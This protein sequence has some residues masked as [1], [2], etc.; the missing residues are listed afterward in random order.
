MIAANLPPYSHIMRRD[1]DR[2]STMVI[3]ESFVTEMRE[4]EPRAITEKL[5]DPDRKVQVRAA[6]EMLCMAGLIN[7]LIKRTPI[8]KEIRLLKL[9]LIIE[10]FSLFRRRG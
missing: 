1:Q 7:R 10:D 2:I 5:N 9:N 8:R 3:E 6:A 4:S